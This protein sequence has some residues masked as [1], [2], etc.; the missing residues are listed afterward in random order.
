MSRIA[1]DIDCVQQASQTA[2]SCLS[3]ITKA[4]NSISSFYWTL[5]NKVLRRRGIEGQLDSICSDLNTLHT[6]IQTLISTV[7]AGCALYSDT[8][9]KVYQLGIQILGFPYKST[10][11][12]MFDQKGSIDFSFLNYKETITKDKIAASASA[13]MLA[14]DDYAWNAL[15][16]D[17]EKTHRK[18]TL[19]TYGLKYENEDG[20]KLYVLKQSGKAEILNKAGSGLTSTDKKVNDFLESKNYRTSVKGTGYSDDAM[21]DDEWKKKYGKKLGNLYEKT[22]GVTGSVSLLE[23]S[24]SGAT[25]WGKG[26]VTAKVGNAEATA[27]LSAGLYV[28]DQNNNR[29]L[30]P[31]VNAKVGASVSALDINA[32][33]QIG[34]D[35]IGLYGKGEVSALSAS[36]NAELGLGMVDGQFQASASASAE[37][38]LAEAGVSAG[39]NVLGGKVGGSAAIN[40]GVG[41][42]ANFGYTDGVVKCELGASLGIGVDLSVEID[43]GGMAET[44]ADGVT[45]AWDD[46]GDFI[47]WW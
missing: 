22:V 37:A 9:D 18:S 21:T 34:S 27:K 1:I 26:S 19:T 40:V 39:M 41:A 33:G 16:L 10:N 25:E 31:G 29:K 32:E 12:A 7:Q 30:S 15:G 23:G 5:P 6:K 2:L 8:E 4:S 38:I 13:F 43:I 42:K 45:S 28:V 44:V 35:M 17:F 3:H 36:A 14:G 47:G 20:S 11:E 24:I 46:L